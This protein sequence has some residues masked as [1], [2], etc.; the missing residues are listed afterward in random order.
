[1]MSH[2]S[3]TNSPLKG[4]LGRIWWPAQNWIPE[5]C[6]WSTCSFVWT[7]F[8][9]SGGRWFHVRMNYLL[10]T[11][12]VNTGS[13]MPKAGRIYFVIHF[14]LYISSF[15]I[16]S[17]EDD[18]YVNERKSEI[19]IL[20]RFVVVSYIYRPWSFLYMYQKFKSH[21]TVINSW[22]SCIWPK[23]IVLFSWEQK[24]SF[25]MSYMHNISRNIATFLLS[26]Y[27]SR[28]VFISNMI[29]LESEYLYNS[30]CIVNAH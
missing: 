8:C 5:A 9:W 10:W 16:K 12:I 23:K 18:I 14:K 15:T 29:C 4:P 7:A 2:S 25:V 20:S 19:I 17:S 28:H 27:F 1:M 6:P 21:S 24:F 30:T 22:Y 11:S 26:L 13:R 3:P